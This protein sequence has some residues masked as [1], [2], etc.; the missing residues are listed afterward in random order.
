MAIILFQDFHIIQNNRIMYWKN[1][2]YRNQRKII[3]RKFIMMIYL[4]FQKINSIQ[5]IILSIKI[6][7]V[8]HN[9][10]K[11]IWKSIRT[12]K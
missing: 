2:N 12:K 10:M 6:K 1:N 5:I 8:Y 4:I 3:N 7:M 11:I 9:K